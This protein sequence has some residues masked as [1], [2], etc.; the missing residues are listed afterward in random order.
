MVQSSGRGAQR[1]VGRES[2]RHKLSVVSGLA[3][4]SLDAMAS[5]APGIA[6]SGW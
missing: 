5:V 4:L 3:A 2:D 1:G 6:M